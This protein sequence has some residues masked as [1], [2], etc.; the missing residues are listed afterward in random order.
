MYVYS[1]SLSVCL[2]PP[3]PSLFLSLSL[4]SPPPPLS[5]SPSLPP[6]LPLS[7]SLSLSPSPYDCHMDLCN[8]SYSY[9]RPSCVAKTLTLNITCQVSAMLI[10]TTDFYH[11]MPLSLTM[12]L[13]GVHKVSAKQKSICF[14][15]SHTFHLI[16]MKFDV[17]MTQFK[18]N[19][20]RLF[21]VRFIETK[22]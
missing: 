3:P 22:E 8:E 4:P 17:V 1:P 18:T 10:G 13:P 19:I 14:I 21:L 7:L 15:F 9:V 12:T 2:P 11:F 6:S 5:L 16:K 20:L